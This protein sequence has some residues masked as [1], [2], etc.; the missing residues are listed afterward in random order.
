MRVALLWIAV[1][2]SVGL[3]CF[4][5]AADLQN[6]TFKQVGTEQGLS[7]LNVT[8]VLRASDGFLWIGT[9]NGL[10]KSDGVSYTVYAIGSTK[11]LQLVNNVIIAIKETS[12]KQLVVLS[13]R[14]LSVIDSNGVVVT[15]MK[16]TPGIAHSLPLDEFND[17]LP[18]PDGKAVL[19]AGKRA[20]YF[21]N[22]KE[23]TTTIYSSDKRLL[24][25]VNKLIPTND[26]LG[27][28]AL[29]EFK[30]GLKFNF[31]NAQIEKVL[32]P[33]QGITTLFEYKNS[34]LVALSNGGL[35][36][37]E[38]G[39]EK[40]LN[41]SKDLLHISEI[42]LYNQILIIGTQERGLYLYDIEN[43]K[44]ITSYYHTVGDVQGLPSNIITSIEIDNQSI[45]WI[46]TNNGMAI[47]DPE[48]IKFRYF[49]NLFRVY[50]GEQYEVNAVAQLPGKQIWVGTSQGIDVYTQGMQ[51]NKS[52]Q[53]INGLSANFLKGSIQELIIQKNN[54][55]IGGANGLVLLE[56]NNGNFKK[57][58]PKVVI[59][60][61][62]YKL[63]VTS[64][65][66]EADTGL[67]IGTYGNGLFYLHIPTNTWKVFKYAPELQFTL[68][69]NQVN[70]LLLTQQGDLIVG[71][72][73]GLNLFNRKFK[74]FVVL[75]CY[76]EEGKT[77]SSDHITAI[78]NYQ[79]NIWVG[80]LDGGL[81]EY[82]ETKKSFKTFTTLAGNPVTTIHSLTAING[83]LWVTSGNRLFV[84]EGNKVVNHYASSAGIQLQQFTKAAS[85]S[86]TGQLILGGIG[87]LIAFNPS[88][89]IRNKVSPMPLITA[90]QINGSSIAISD[91][92]ELEADENYINIWYTS[93]NL[94]APD[95]N[96]FQY[97]LLGSDTTWLS[98]GTARMVAFN[99]L[100]PGSY[101]FQI[102]ALNNDGISS[103]LKTLSITINPTIYA[104]LWFRIL[105]A[106]VVISIVSYILYL[107]INKIKQEKEIAEFSTR[108][109]SLRNQALQSQLNPHFIFNA[110]NSIQEV[111]LSGDSK[112]AGIYLNKFARLLR[113]ILEYSGID[114]ISL[115]E[116]LKTIELY[117]EV[118]SL[119]FSNEF[120]WEV[121]I[122]EDLDTDDFLIPPLL[123]Q[124]IVENAIWHGLRQKQGSK[125]ITIDIALV[126]TQLSIA[127]T[128][129]GVGF[130][131]EG[132]AKNTT[133]HKK[134][135]LGI[136]FTK[137]R[138][139]VFDAQQ[140]TVSAMEISPSVNGGTQVLLL[141]GQSWLLTK[142]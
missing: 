124:P 2:W 106:V 27:F 53:Y 44:P 56:A 120:S 91:R 142:K 81:S 95:E 69:H 33:D 89:I 54:L 103:Q 128:D 80:T 84:L 58:W 135:S 96:T 116:E 132:E 74:N 1:F 35:I 126:I 75:N 60:N 62:E 10:L 110:L 40:Y 140:G 9:R 36:A 41:I 15:Q 77:L 49:T 99:A 66:T 47:F 64:L 29:T 5:Q 18:T 31:S 65:V 111:V 39:K 134:K 4:G 141:I 13:S 136:S 112:G 26:K 25:G 82:S 34:L 107:V 130:P 20:L 51:Y 119:R 23:R 92:L 121:E 113:R 45:M 101:S 6:M 97:R 133:Q 123:L 70:C 139:A 7:N 42:K 88:E 93:L 14:G 87:G 72:R 28:W 71:T 90:I 46:G 115:T 43:Q 118:E 83:K 55:W 17:I 68:S 22:L 3:A 131:K 127:I 104:S 8:T 78:A 125:I 102:R 50:E 57:E 48:R 32:L 94:S 73:A 79:N 122:E 11:S 98:A 61:I 137:E 117:L 12:K 30:G 21:I 138:L 85:Y 52:L 105:V 76:G 38:N 37:I 63:D 114:T 129:N 100:N 108:L 86:N 16:I 59:G 24:N 19:L 67:W 109:T